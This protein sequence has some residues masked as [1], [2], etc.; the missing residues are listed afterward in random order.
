M[1]QV[2]YGAITITDITDIESVQNWY[3]AT[4]LSSGVTKSNPSAGHGTWTTNI[5]N[6]TLTSTFQYL[7]NYEEILGTGSVE[8]SS[9]QPIIIGHFGINGTNGIN[10]VDGNSIISIDEYYQITNST[11]NPGSSGWQ[12]NT[13]VIP[14]SS[15]RYLWNYQVVNYSKTTPEGSSNEAR[16]IGVYGE[17]GT[18]ILKVTTAPTSASGQVSGFT[19]SYRISTS[20]VKTQ[21]GKSEVLIGDIIEY[22]SNHY[23]VGYVNSSYVYLSSATSIKGADGQTYYTHILYS[24]KSSPTSS[25][26][27][28]SSPSGKTY[29]AIQITTN[30]A[31]PAWDDA[32][33]VWMKYIGTDGE[34][35]PQG[36]S[37]TNVRELYYLKTNSTIPSQI[38]WNSSTSQPSQTIYSNDRQNSW[39]SVTPTYVANA[40]YYTCIET[41]LSNNTKV[42]S[43]P[44]I[45]NA[46]TNANE[47]AF[48]ANNAVSLLGG[49]FMHGESLSEKTPASAR[50]IERIKV[51]NTDV[52]LNPS[53]WLH[54]VIIGSNGI[55]LR[56][57]EAIMAQ[58]V[59]DS[60]NNNAAL[61][62]NQPPTINNG[63]IEEGEKAMELTGGALNFY[64]SN[65][66]TPDSY[67]GTNGLVTNKGI[68][69]SWVIDLN[70]IHSIGKEIWDEDKNGIFIGSREDL[71]T[72][73][74]M[75][76]LSGGK[77]QYVPTEDD[78]VYD[79]TEYY[80]LTYRRTTDTLLDGSVIY[81]YYDNS[82]NKYL[83]IDQY[84][85]YNYVASTDTS[86]KEGKIYYS[87]NSTT[88]KYE[89]VVNPSGNPAGEGWREAILKN[90]SEQTN[91][92]WYVKDYILI[93]NPEEASGTPKDNKWY[94]S[95]GP[96]WYINSD[97]SASF[98]SLIV[99]QYGSLDVPAA[100]ISGKLRAD[101]I[102]VDN[103]SS[104]SAIIGATVGQE[105]TIST[106][107]IDTFIKEILTF[108]DRVVDKKEYFRTVGDTY[109]AVD[110]LPFKAKTLDEEVDELKTYYYYNNNSGFAS[111]VAVTTTVN[112]SGF[113]DGL[114]GITNNLGKITFDLEQL[115]DTWFDDY[116]DYG[117]LV[118]NNVD[119]T[120]TIPANFM[121]DL[122]DNIDRDLVDNVGYSNESEV[123]LIN[124]VQYGLKVE[125][126]PRESLSSSWIG[127]LQIL[128]ESTEEYIEV[129][130]KYT[131]EITEDEVVDATK[132]YY[133]RTGTEGNYTYIVVSNP[134]G[135]P[136]ERDYYERFS[137]NPNEEEWYEDTSSPVLASLYEKVN[138][139]SIELT[140]TKIDYRLTQDQQK[141]LG[142]EYYFFDV[143]YKVTTDLEP[144]EN[145]IYYTYDIENNIY[146]AVDLSIE[147]DNINPVNNNWYER[148]AKYS[149][150]ED[151]EVSNPFNA[152][153]YEKKNVYTSQIILQDGDASMIINDE[154]VAELNAKTNKGFNIFKGN[155]DGNLKVGNLEIIPYKGGLAIRA[156]G[157]EN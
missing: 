99:N 60:N 124:D 138:Q 19:Y 88:G 136:F 22:N 123:F 69:G 132:T 133:I 6:A 44:V 156:G 12:K 126:S 18:S 102:E 31:S 41:S 120:S 105:D 128:K 146:T 63:I 121:E 35:G 108:D 50:I 92:I 147:S 91:P 117:I 74:Q 139:S 10:G 62:F 81:Y 71:G 61:V 152:Y 56:Y 104:I 145:K 3:L 8:I 119:W 59:V 83:E 111:N 23:R 113:N 106:L 47:K 73:R 36:I 112:N 118:V 116:N 51:G 67:L 90:P 94:E 64:G 33:W 53:K 95:A 78:M 55:N 16:I 34:I 100:N 93:D 149:I 141:I 114:H 46:L 2:S 27:V 26:D 148:V 98:G 42:W 77:I 45:N 122:F 101:Q 4:D 52:T 48:I 68:I 65:Q 85:F 103:L 86:I 154:E 110:S 39:T 32:G 127:T 28:D 58:L 20:T 70:S 135:N 151:S 130:D 129:T 107:V 82:T 137:K 80:E 5:E 57:N 13:I 79:T 142:K 109:K 140:T 11:T 72:G 29:V 21:S 37:V 24:F 144:K 143:D 17:R 25:S 84:D 75:Y 134:A 97:G 131:Y 76:T 115:Y 9:T 96:M 157:T 14:T 89:V 43:A 15:Q 155:I 66:I 54:N 7:W 40:I 38:T 150:A 49:H 87:Y 153:W 30:Q 1:A 125:W